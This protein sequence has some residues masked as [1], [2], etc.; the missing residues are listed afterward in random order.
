MPKEDLTRPVSP[1]FRWFN[2][3]TGEPLLTVGAV[4][5]TRNLRTECAVCGG[6]GKIERRSRPLPHGGTRESAV[7]VCPQGH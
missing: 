7:L 3:D 4:L 5:Q 1:R 6:K 2:A